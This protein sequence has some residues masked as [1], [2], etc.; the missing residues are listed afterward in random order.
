MQITANMRAVGMSVSTMVLLMCSN[1]GNIVFNWMFIFGH[2]GFHEWGPIGA[3]WATVVARGAAAI[4]GLLLLVRSHPAIRVTLSG[5]MPRARFMW[6]VMRAGM[7]VALQWTVR[8]AAIALLSV[9]KYKRISLPSI[10]HR[11]A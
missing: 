11:L 9:G 5:W 3:A 8:M 6:A 10:S 1:L 2:L 4:V 7:P